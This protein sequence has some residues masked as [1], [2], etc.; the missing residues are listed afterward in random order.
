MFLILCFFLCAW[1]MEMQRW[2]LELQQ[3]HCDKE[4]WAW[5]KPKVNLLKMAAAPCLEVPILF[6]SELHLLN[7]EYICPCLF[8][9]YLPSK[10]LCS[11]G[12][13]YMKFNLDINVHKSVILRVGKFSVE[14][15]VSIVIRGLGLISVLFRLLIA[16]YDL[17]KVND[18][19]F[20]FS[21]IICGG[22][23]HSLSTSQL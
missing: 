18:Y 7:L 14:K 6:F 3:P 20:L 23:L 12:R 13:I 9:S 1:N 11:K 15:Y 2:C 21:F 22:K 16:W 5:E 17:M 8:G 19:G 10:W 4:A